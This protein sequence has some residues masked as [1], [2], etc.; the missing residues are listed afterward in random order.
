MGY[1]HVKSKVSQKN[2]DRARKEQSD[3]QTLE[4]ATLNEIPL[5]DRRKEAKKPLFLIRYE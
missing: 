4:Y 2:F 5:E 3:G 1:Q